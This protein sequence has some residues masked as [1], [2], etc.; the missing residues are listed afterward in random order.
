MVPPLGHF[1]VLLLDL[2]S[3]G[4]FGKLQDFIELG[5]VNLLVNF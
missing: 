5:V 2:L 4:I 3:R 1:T